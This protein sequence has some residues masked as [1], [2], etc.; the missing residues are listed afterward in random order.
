MRTMRYGERLKLARGKRTQAWL[1]EESGVS[2]SLI[3]QLEN[4]LT[5]TGS[6]YTPRLARALCV[7]VDWLADEIGIMCDPEVRE[8][9]PPEYGR[10]V[11]EE[12][13]LLRA[14][15]LASPDLRRNMLRQ[16]K[17]ILEDLENPLP[18][19]GTNNPAAD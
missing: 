13:I 5:A 17:G 14:F 2:Q 16:A 15:R 18:L 6:E 19:T 12:S 3:S 8:S 7:R 4:S 11:D 10:N 9:L 1:A